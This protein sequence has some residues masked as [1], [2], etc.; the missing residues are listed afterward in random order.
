MMINVETINLL[1]RKTLDFVHVRSYRCPVMLVAGDHSPH[2]N[3]TVDMNSKMDPESCQ[4]MK[5][6]T[7]TSFVKVAILHKHCKI[8]H[9]YRPRFVFALMIYQLVIRII[10]EI[11]NSNT[12]PYYTQVNKTMYEKPYGHG[13]IYK[14]QFEC[15]GM[16]ME[17]A[18]NKLAESF[19]LFLQGMGYGKSLQNDL[20]ILYR[21]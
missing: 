8:I 6:C 17:E 18:P 10:V 14:F 11:L 7:C 4:W 20:F 2:L 13:S 5:V 19:R 1:P 15:G 3:D 12:L 21:I 9:Y 16:I